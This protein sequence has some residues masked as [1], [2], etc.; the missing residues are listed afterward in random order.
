MFIHIGNRKT[1]SDKLII[2][3]FNVETILKSEINSWIKKEL[4]AEYKVITIG[5]NNEITGSNVS[6]FTI[7]NRKIINNEDLIW[8][9][10]NVKGL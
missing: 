5:I 2:G 1:V 4:N 10:D 6:P 7:I 9:R 8:S 3:I